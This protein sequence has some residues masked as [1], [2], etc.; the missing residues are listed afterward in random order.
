MDDFD[1]LLAEGDVPEKTRGYKAKEYTP[2]ENFVKNGTEVLEMIKAGK[3]NSHWHELKDGVWYVECKNATS[4]IAVAPGVT[5]RG[6]VDPAKAIAFLEAV[7]KKAV[8]GDYDAE[9]ERTRRKSPKKASEKTA[10]IIEKY[11]A[12]GASAH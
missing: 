1:A 2:R 9:F 4:V 11:K 12:N 5:R 3:P 6:W 7:M 10:N 8:A